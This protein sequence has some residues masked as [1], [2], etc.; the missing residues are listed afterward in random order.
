MIAEKFGICDDVKNI[1]SSINP[2]KHKYDCYI[3]GGWFSPSK[4]KAIDALIK[5]CSQL[6]MKCYMPQFDSPQIS[7]D[8]PDDVRQLNF[9]SNLDGI[10]N[11]SFV[12]ASTEGLDSGTIW[13]CGYA[14]AHGIPVFGYAPLLP[15]GTKF[16][17]MLAQSMEE[18]FL[19]DEEL[20]DYFKHGI[21]PDKIGA[22]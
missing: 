9:D 6:Y 13:E 20:L 16:N 19:S 1:I 4:R 7:K 2:G 3:A 21:K 12:I 11:S 14:Y 17:L 22:F 15:P 5:D 18:V 10:R 8:S